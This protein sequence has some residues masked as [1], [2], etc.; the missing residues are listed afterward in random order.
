MNRKKY[1]I[2]ELL[3]LLYVMYGTVICTIPSISNIIGS[4]SILVNFGVGILLFIIN[5]KKYDSKLL[6]FVGIMIINSIAGALINNTGFGSLTTIMNLYIMFLYANKINIHK[7]FI[8]SSA[9]IIFIGNLLFL[10]AGKSNY[11]TNSIGYLG[12]IMIVFIFILYENM[13][14]KTLMMKTIMLIMVIVNIVTIYLSLSRASLMGVVMF[15]LIMIFPFFITNK[16]I[17]RSISL[18]L[19]I[20][21]ILFPYIYVG[22]WKHNVEINFGTKNKNFYSGRQMIWSR[23]MKEFEGKELYG[24][25][26]NFRTNST[27][28]SLNVHNSLFA[29]YMI[30]GAINFAVF[31]PLFVRFIWKMQEKSKNKVN[32]IAIAGIIGMLVI[33]YYE[34]NLIW[35]DVYMFFV[36]LS[37]IAYSKEENDDIEERKAYEKDNS[38]YT[39]I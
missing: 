32:R 18:L 22:M 6:F 25:G 20:G 19:I 9:T 15:F 26:S 7:R 11:N 14:R 13:E 24:I 33:S 10:L 31:L 34:T 12:F 4:Y 27:S 36:I 28:T 16:K 5:V 38:I 2:Q 8:L 37:C 21:S 35:S 3:L 1:N 23:M 30:Y 17:F 29:I 39:N